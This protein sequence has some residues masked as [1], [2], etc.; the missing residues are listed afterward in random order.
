MIKTWS[1]L[2]NF[3]KITLKDFNSEFQT[4]IRFYLIQ[5]YHSSC[6][7]F[8]MDD[9]C[10]RSTVNDFK[11]KELNKNIKNQNPGGCFDL[12]ANQNRQAV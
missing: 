2:S 8:I 3:Y 9:K 5:A 10:R 12:L 4:L 1:N 11:Y 7:E 6:I